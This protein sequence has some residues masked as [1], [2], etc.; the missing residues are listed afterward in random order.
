[1]TG[2]LDEA[3]I[4]EEEVRGGMQAT[5]GVD[6]RLSSSST[7]MVVSSPSK[8]SSAIIELCSGGIRWI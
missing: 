2:L 6:S 3:I 7:P 5:D 4:V 8:V 1:M